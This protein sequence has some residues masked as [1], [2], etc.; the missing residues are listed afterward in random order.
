VSSLLFLDSQSPLRF[1][2]RLAV[3]V[4]AFAVVVEVVIK[5]PSH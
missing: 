3:A 4:A 2:C 5:D 1:T